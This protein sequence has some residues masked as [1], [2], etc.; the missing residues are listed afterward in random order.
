[1]GSDYTPRY[2]WR[3]TW[4]DPG[5]ADSHKTDFSGWDEGICIGRI[6]LQPH[7]LTKGTWMWSGHGPR[8]RERLFPHQG[9]QPTAR[10]AARMVEDYY[11][12]LMAHNSGK[13]E[14]PCTR[15]TTT[16]GT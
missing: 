16:T 10:D 3:I 15:S 4:P 14:T 13:E 2:K 8:V 9:Y 11:E 6:T 1:M 5:D 7:G 12:R